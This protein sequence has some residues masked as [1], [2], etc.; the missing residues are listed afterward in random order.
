MLDGTIYSFGKVLPGLVESLNLSNTQA[1]SIGS[2]QCG[3]FYLF[4]PFICAIVNKYGFRIVAVIGAIF[5]TLGIYHSF[6]IT[7]F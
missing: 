3:M 2:I 6:A 5:A 4:G 1:A 7:S